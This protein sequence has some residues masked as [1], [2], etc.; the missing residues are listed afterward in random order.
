LECYVNEEL[1]FKLLA[2]RAV[3]V[4]P[5]E[6]EQKFNYLETDSR[7]LKELDD[8]LVRTKEVEIDE[9]K[10]NVEEVKINE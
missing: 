7:A 9:K 4:N 3:W 6:K 1:G 2:E 10:I 5:Y 8:Y